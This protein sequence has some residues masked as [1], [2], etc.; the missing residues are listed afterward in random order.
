MNWWTSCY[1][2]LDLFWDDWMRINPFLSRFLDRMELGGD[3]FAH[4]RVHISGPAKSE[5]MLL[6][7]KLHS[8]CSAPGKPF[9]KV[10]CSELPA[11]FSEALFFGFV[12]GFM[13][14]GRHQRDGYFKMANSGLLF[15]DEIGW[16]DTDFQGRL[17]K[18]LEEGSFRLLGSEDP[19]NSRFCLVSGTSSDLEFKSELGRF[20][21][22]LYYRLSEFQIE[23]PPIGKREIQSLVQFF[24]EKLCEIRNIRQTSISDESVAMLSQYPFPG[25]LEEL[26][27]I[28]KH[29]MVEANGRKIQIDHLAP[30]SPVLKHLSP[31][32]LAGSRA[33]GLQELPG[34]EEVEILN[35]V[36]Q[37]GHITNT[38]CRDLLKVDRYRAS[39]LL[40]KLD[41]MGLLKCIGRG[42]N[43]YYARPKDAI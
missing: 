9:I 4:S 15:M 42:R 20:R 32:S 17:L 41:A 24:I 37:N 13:G 28:L 8:M 6:A 1:D 31:V 12:P 18:F 26:F 22:D 27:T 11:A 21:P 3:G 34:L 40:K 7:S 23:I 43:A 25:D 38:R 29:A 35:F 33:A 16:L 5:R 10:D 2:I 19:I 14:W 39:Y 36:N 30:F